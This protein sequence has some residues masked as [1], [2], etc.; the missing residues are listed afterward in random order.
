[1]FNFC[2]HIIEHI[3]S[4]TITCHQFEMVRLKTRYL[5]FEI[6]YPEGIDSLSEDY[7]SAIRKP[8]PSNIDAKALSRLLRDTIEL[9]FGDF[10]T[11]SIASTISIKYFSNAT[12]TGILRVGRDH[13]RLAWGAL[14]YISHIGDHRVVINITRVSGTIKKCEQA[15][16]KKNK[17]SI[18]E[19]RT[20][21]FEGFVVVDDL[22]IIED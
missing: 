20:K 8:S 10:G 13:F 6:L 16:I 7:G 21:A 12:S 19:R 4:L 3:R 18:R 1:M 15:A 9:N 14:S 22:E 5:L 11:G 2:P 17:H